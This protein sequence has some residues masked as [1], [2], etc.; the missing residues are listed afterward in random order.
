MPKVLREIGLER[1]KRK[2]VLL[3]G[4]MLGQ[5]AK[6]IVFD[7]VEIKSP[8]VEIWPVKDCHAG[9]IVCI[10]KGRKQIGKYVAKLI[11]KLS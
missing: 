1:S 8:K 7:G 6:V 10:R 3:S 9:D 2:P 11:K 5:A 4:K